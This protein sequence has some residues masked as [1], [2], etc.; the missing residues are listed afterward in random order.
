MAELK[1]YLVTATAS[2]KGLNPITFEINA[3]DETQAYWT[4]V[5]FLAGATVEVTEIP[6]DAE[7]ADA[8]VP[9]EPAEPTN[10]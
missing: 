5:R 4:A 10:A 6:P 3:A 8:E 1:K 9:A 2:S 7:I